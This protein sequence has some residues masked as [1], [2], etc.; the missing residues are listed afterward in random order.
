VSVEEVQEATGFALAGTDVSQVAQTR[1]P[2]DEELRL[3][4]EVVDPEDR[5]EREV[6]RR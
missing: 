2:T 3:I 5:R 6:P 1:M 4:R